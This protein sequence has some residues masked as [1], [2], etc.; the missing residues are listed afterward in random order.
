MA[1]QGKMLS[2]CDFESHRVR[3]GSFSKFKKALLN[4]LAKT[5]DLEL[6]IS[7]ISNKV[8]NLHSVIFVEMINAR[9]TD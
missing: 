9:V 6:N 1:F 2:H 5:L 3:L 7:L 8:P 4:H